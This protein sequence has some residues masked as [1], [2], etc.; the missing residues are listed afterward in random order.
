MQRRTGVVLLWLSAFGFIFGMLS[1]VVGQAMTM[2]DK[3]CSSSRLSD[4]KS[5]AWQYAEEHNGKLPPLG[6]VS[7]AHAALNSPRRV[8]SWEIIRAPGRFYQPNPSLSGKVLDKIADADETVLFYEPGERYGSRAVVFVDGHTR[9]IPRASWP[10]LK[11]QSKITAPDGPPLPEPS[12]TL[13]GRILWQLSPELFF[14]G[15]L[16]FL[17]GKLNT[18]RKRA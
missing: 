9:R 17:A 10:A 5:A 11:K 6:S 18:S 13:L 16:L 8:D 14:V 12:A 15:G 3:V 7:E 1:T 2:S 4:L